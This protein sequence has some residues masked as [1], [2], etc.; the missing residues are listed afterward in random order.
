MYFY[1]EKHVEIKNLRGGF[2]GVSRIPWLE[3]PAFPENTVAHERNLPEK[4][5]T[6]RG[7]AEL[8]LSAVEGKEKASLLEAGRD[9]YSPLANPERVTSKGVV[10]QILFRSL[11]SI[12]DHSKVRFTAKSAEALLRY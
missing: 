10:A 11:K 4:W 3:F 6:H 1:R 5:G 7:R 12:F 2:L 8:V 9:K